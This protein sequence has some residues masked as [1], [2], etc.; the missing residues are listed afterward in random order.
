MLHVWKLLRL[1]FSA[2][3]NSLISWETVTRTIKRRSIRPVGSIK[4][5]LPETDFIE[6]IINFIL[7]HPN[8]STVNYSSLW[9]LW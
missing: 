5:K 7:H 2:L 9:Y 6:K 3:H 4:V 1:L 8:K